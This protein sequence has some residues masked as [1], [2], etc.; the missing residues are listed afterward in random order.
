MPLVIFFLFFLAFFT[1]ISFISL[2]LRVGLSVRLISLDSAIIS[3]G[4]FSLLRKISS[5]SF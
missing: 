1:L 5:S 3:V 2:F 4:L